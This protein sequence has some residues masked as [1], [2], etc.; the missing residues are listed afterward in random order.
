MNFPASSERTVLL[1]RVAH[2][3][4]RGANADAQA[5]AA[6]GQRQ[7]PD[8]AELAHL[9]AT[10]LLHLGRREEARQILL[11]AEVAAPD[12]ADLQRD[13][14][15]IAVEDGDTDGASRRLQSALQHEPGH[16]G[17]LFDQGQLLLR[18]AEYAK[19]RDA[20]ATAIRRAPQDPVL[21]LGMASAEL[22]L[23]DPVQA[24]RHVGEALRHAPRLAAAHALHGHVLQA[25]RRF[26]D[27]ANAYL[28]AA[29]E[30][31]RQA[32]YPLLAGQMLDESGQLE[33]ASEAY[34]RAYSLDPA[35]GAALAQL[36]F[37]RR[38][39]CDW[40]D[41]DALTG[42][43]QQAVAEGRAG[44]APFSFLAED[45]DAAA[46]RRCAGTF[47]AAVEQQAAPLQRQLGFRYKLA[48]PDAPMKV[49]FVSNGFGE[50]PIGLLTVALFE[51]LARDGVLELHLFATAPDDGG[52]TRRRLAAA[53]MIHESAALDPPQLARH[54]HAA[55]IEILFDLRGYG[56][57]AN[58]D[59]FELCPAPLQVNWLAYPATSGSPW[60]DYVLADPVVLPA[61]LRAGFS[62]K[63]LRLPRCFQPYDPG[64]VPAATPSRE[65]CGL[66]ARGTVFAS[67]N[68]SYKIN[69]ASFARFMV[70]LQLVPGSV[71]WLQSGP[72][73]ADERLRR[74]A[75]AAQVAPERLVFLPRLPHAEYLARYAHVDLFLD[76]LPYNAHTTAVDALWS[77]CP[78]LTCTGRTLAGRVA[79]SL[80][81]HL[82]LPELV[83]TDADSYVSMAVE[84]GNDPAALA[85]LR[86]HLQRQREHNALF[87]MQGFAVDFRR[88]VQAI[89]ARQRIGRP[90]IDL[91]F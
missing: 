17:L 46:Q 91:D 74:A 72:G 47:A 76:T 73:N 75:T 57:G 62:E 7:F 58:T 12:H 87:D 22:E 4:Q 49:G 79:A 86:E 61:T 9:H 13:L 45:A 20:F 60:M 37:A 78:L 90:P 6:A 8:D 30:A 68:N 88:A 15:S 42:A 59:L 43:I 3:L 18:G 66:P 53:A 31:P 27:A 55:G 38:R 11:L 50:H 39:L 89:G 29:Q 54:I 2:L 70:I 41:L 44:I 14:A 35:S 1:Q 71:L 32:Q 77:G 67:F 28:R 40:R 65:A 19:A 26:E 52:P 56:A 24:G 85:T 23:G 84:L 64:R 69:P 25:Q 5:L 16:P 33:R 10:A 36:L 51:A 81:Y 80:L 48:T 34:A 83:T 63:V 82:G 21:H